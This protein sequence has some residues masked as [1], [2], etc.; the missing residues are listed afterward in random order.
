MSRAEV[1]TS[2]T[3]PF[4]SKK[5]WIHLP[6]RSKKRI[7]PLGSE[8]CIRSKD[9]E[10]LLKFACVYRV[11]E[12]GKVEVGAFVRIYVERVQRAAAEA[13]V[14]KSGGGGSAFAPLVMTSLAKY[15][16]RMGMVH[17]R[18]TSYRGES[19]SIR[20]KDNLV[21]VQVGPPSR[22]LPPSI[23]IEEWV[24]RGFR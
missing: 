15:E 14:T 9:V 12:E 20:S 5:R 11:P 13:I 21:L 22:P 24:F 18:V 7:S 4:P 3:M 19:N 6:G 17:W 2:V 1:L 10:K 23:Y 16:N 8:V